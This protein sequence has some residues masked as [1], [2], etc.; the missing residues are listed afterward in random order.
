MMYLV[1][2]AQV[3][4]AL[5][6]IGY[7]SLVFHAAKPVQN[8]AAKVQENIDEIG[9]ALRNSTKWAFFFWYGLFFALATAHLVKTI[10]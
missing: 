4:A 9:Q 5:W 10:G 1:I 8:A 7:L 6:F 2:G 3:M